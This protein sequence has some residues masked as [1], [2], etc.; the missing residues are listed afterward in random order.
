MTTE[1]LLEEFA[2]IVW[3]L[4][5]AVYPVTTPALE[6]SLHELDALFS[7]IEKEGIS[8]AHREVAAKDASER[9][10]FREEHLGDAVT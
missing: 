10:P 9:W 6:A 1:E 2:A 7:R 4:G 5:S 8:P 3:R